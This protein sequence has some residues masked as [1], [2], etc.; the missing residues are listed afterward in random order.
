MLAASGPRDV[1]SAVERLAL[2]RERLRRAMMPTPSEREGGH[3]RGD[4]IGGWAAL[5]VDRITAIPGAR[6]LIEAV[7]T[8]WSQHPLHA[9]GL[10][11]AEASRKLAAPIAERNPLTLVF[12]ALLFGAVLALTRP[13]RWLL[14][15][16]LF[17][18]LLPALVASVMREL[19]VDSWLKIFAALSAPGAGRA[20]PAPDRARPSNPTDPLRPEPAPTYP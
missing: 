5:L 6:V 4:G 8:W 18:G 2:S 15:P 3:T 16:A 9:A 10:V 13:W 14:R 19:P 7:R 12:G 11:A 20:S 1:A 17:A